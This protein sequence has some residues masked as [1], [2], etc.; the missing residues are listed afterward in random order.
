MSTYR[1]EGVT[2]AGNVE[3]SVSKVVKQRKMLRYDPALP[4]H[5]SSIICSFQSKYEEW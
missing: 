5:N 4:I 1:R 2:D 3:R